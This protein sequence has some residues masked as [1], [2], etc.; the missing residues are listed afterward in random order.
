MAGV[1]DTIVEIVRFQ[2]AGL[3]AIS[4]RTAAFAK[5]LDEATKRGKALSE[6]L[7]D[8]AFARHASRMAE[9]NRHAERG[10]VAIKNQQRAADL[11]SGAFSKHAAAMG[12]LSAESRKLDQQESLAALV[13]QH[14]RFGGVIRHNAAQLS[15]LGR[16]AMGVTGMGVAMG[17]GLVRSGLQGTVQGYQLERAWTRLARQLAAIA[18]PAV[19]QLASWIGRLASWFQSLSGSQ[20]DNILKFGLL[21][22]GGLALVGVLKTIITVGAAARTV[23]ASVG[24][25]AGLG[26]LGGT[27]VGAAG[28][29][30]LGMALPVVGAATAAYALAESSG[31]RLNPSEGPGDYYARKRAEGRSRLGAI[32]STAGTALGFVGRELFGGKESF[33]EDAKTGKKHRDVTPL[34]VAQDEAGGAH[35]RIQEELLKVTSDRTDAERELKESIDE[36]RVAIE[37]EKAKGSITAGDAESVAAGYEFFLRRA[38]AMARGGK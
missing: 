34:Q 4:A 19:E 2:E 13:A 3:D 26:A 27:A 23:L 28:S 24:A 25:S 5:Q 29:R 1:N 31:D 18:I 6:A 30:A 22:A 20:Q 15:L 11:A 32:A 10:A 7:G 14:G 8:P 9:L 16:V 33:V 38:A 36:L 12:R 17:V 35:M 21:A 37:A